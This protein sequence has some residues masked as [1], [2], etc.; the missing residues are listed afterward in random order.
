MTKICH[1]PH[2]II[3]I[4]LSS[5]IFICPAITL[6][7][8]QE[9]KEYKVL[10]G[11]TLWDISAKELKDPFLWPKIW[12]ENPDVTNPDRINPG[13]TIKIPLYLLQKKA[14]PEEPIQ[15]AKPEIKKE[16]PQKPV[17]KKIE[18]IKRN[19]LVHRNILIS[20]GYISESIKSRGKI[21]GTP[22]GRSLLGKYDYAYIK[23]DSPSNTGDKF[24]IIRSAG[25]VRHPEINNTFG[26]LIEVLGV[27]EI[28]GIE[29]GETKTKI[30]ES[31]SDVLTGDLLD[32]FY[33]IEP[34]FEI[35]RPRKPAISGFIV[36]TKHM[37]TINGT[38]D[39]VY[40]DK[41]IKDGLEVGDVLKIITS[42]ELHKPNGIIQI[43]NLKDST[44]TA[45]V[46]TSA[47]EIKIGD[48][49]RGLK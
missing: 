26:Y 11:D 41:G 2:T 23:T 30:I 29:N 20:S 22:S 27:A 5:F 19:Y 3:F 35:D 16:E 1:K 40:I 10:K 34:P 14:A 17:S 45:I 15:E 21:I 49:I 37:R 6:A 42:G 13:Q 39:I 25:I 8:T 33:E 48:G 4:I 38:W 9:Y 24:Y 12:K 31:Y 44:A 43:I 28:I 7:Q 47:D 32:N 36:A 18:P 46:R